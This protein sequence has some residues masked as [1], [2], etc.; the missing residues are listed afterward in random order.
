MSCLIRVP[1]P[2]LVSGKVAGNLDKVAAVAGLGCG[3]SLGVLP[4]FLVSLSFL[5]DM[6]SLV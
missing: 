1:Q 2:V 4:F 5:F 3:C 6:Y